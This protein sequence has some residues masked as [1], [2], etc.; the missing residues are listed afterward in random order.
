M[1][2]VKDIPNL[3]KKHINVISTQHRKQKLSQTTIVKKQ[4][5]IQGSVHTIGTAATAKF[6]SV[7]SM[8]D[9]SFAGITYVCVPAL[10]MDG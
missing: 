1:W 3:K 9:G 6:F 5:L 4:H 8:Q 2:T 7:K 10:L